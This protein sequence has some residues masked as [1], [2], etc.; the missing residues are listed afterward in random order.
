MPPCNNDPKSSY[1]GTEPSPKGLGWAAHAEQ[2]GK[3][4][5]GNDGNMYEVVIRSDNKTQY[6]A[7][8]KTSTK[9]KK[10]STSIKKSTTKKKTHST[11]KKI[12]LKK[13]KIPAF[14][15]KKSTNKKKIPTSNKKI[16]LKM[17]KIPAF[18]VKR[19]TTKKKTPTSNKKTNSKKKHLTTEKYLSILNDN[20]SKTPANPNWHEWEKKYPTLKII[21]THMTDALNKVGIDLYIVP[22]SYDST[23]NGYWINYVWDY[24]EAKF[25]NPYDKPTLLGNLKL[26]QDGTKILFSKFEFYHYLPTKKNKDNVMKI[27]TLLFP[28]RFSWNGEQLQVISIQL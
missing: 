26:N 12:S 19:S 27:G 8:I 24:V 3:R 2:V 4:R 14:S 16:S 28:K 17:K 1:K 18:S 7:P 20:F 25:R 5:R 9:K 22:Q 15:V 13:T 11:K 10:I 23:I 21:R 6:W